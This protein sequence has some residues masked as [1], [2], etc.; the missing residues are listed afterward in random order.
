MYIIIAGAGEVGSHIASL[1]IEAKHEVAIIEQSGEIVDSVRRQLEVNTI[2]GN[3]ATPKVLKATEV[4]RADLIIAVTNND[5]TNMLTCFLAKE[6]GAAM[7]VARVRNP[8]YSGYF[9]TAAKSS[10]TLRKVIRPISLG[11]DLFINPEFEVAKEITN[12]FSSFYPSPV[13]NFA[14]GRVQIKEF[15]VGEKKTLKKALGKIKFTKPCVVAAI[16]RAGE[17]IMPAVDEIIKPDDHIYLVASREHMDDLGEMFASPQRPVNNVVILGGGRIGTL[18]AE[19]LH[20]QGISVKVIEKDIIRGEEIAAKLEGATVL[21]GDGTDRDFLIEQ[22][23][24]SAD[25]FV[26]T[27]ESDELNILCGLLAKNL[28]VPRSIIMAKKPGYIPLAEAIGIDVVSSPP[29]LTAG[30]IAHFIL[31]GGAISAAY[32]GGKEMQA[33]EFVISSKAHVAQRKIS[34]AGLPKKAIIGGIVHNDTV[35]IPPNDSTI[36]PG[37]HVIII[38]PLSVIPEVEKLF[39]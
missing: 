12:L 21:Q 25:A 1:L 38:S 28:G 35:I 29:L 23:V 8:E 24:P 5:E 26:A 27:T 36:Q 9:I 15:K 3:A 22:G 7:T 10:P 34:K 30:K 39:K 14:D 20:K 18:I 11:I 4:H 31:H 37:D 6:L 33:I 17:T 16:S 32:I 13:E 2:I 19:G